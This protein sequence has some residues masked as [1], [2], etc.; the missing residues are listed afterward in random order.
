MDPNEPVLRGSR[1]RC[2]VVEPYLHEFSSPFEQS[3][4]QIFPRVSGDNILLAGTRLFVA[5]SGIF[6]SAAHIFKID[7]NRKMKKI[8]GRTDLVD[9]PKIG[10]TH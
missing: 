8:K 10:S 5:R 9:T 1:T 6:V 4:F 2:C 7:V 3:E